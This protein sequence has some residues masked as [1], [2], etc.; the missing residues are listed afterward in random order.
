[1]MQ[2]KSNAPAIP[3]FLIDSVPGV[4]GTRGRELLR[5][6]GIKADARAIFTWLKQLR[7]A[8]YSYDFIDNRNRKSP[9]YI[10]ENLP[11]LRPYAH[12]LLAFHVFSFEEDSF[13]A[14]RFC[15][16][17]NPPVNRYMKSLFLEYR[18]SGQGDRTHLWCKV[19]GHFNRGLLSRGFF[20]FFSIANKIMMTRQLKNIRKLSERTASGNIRTGTFDL[21]NYFIHRGIHWWIF[22][23][24]PQCKGLLTPDLP[25]GSF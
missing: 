9:G 24:R 21:G 4:P 3:S 13:I 14:C 1:M 6:I 5:R 10:I 12:F 2:M 20:F 8:P 16:P 18:I 15:E 22:C 19:R 11:P 17:V 25:N 23:R 7:V